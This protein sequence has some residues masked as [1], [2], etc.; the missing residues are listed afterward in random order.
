MNTILLSIHQMRYP[1]STPQ[2]KVA[3][4]KLSNNASHF[5]VILIKL[6]HANNMSKLLVFN[7]LHVI[8][9]IH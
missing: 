2:R 1:F 8:D 5:L 4:K 7:V 9:V 3:I 6:P